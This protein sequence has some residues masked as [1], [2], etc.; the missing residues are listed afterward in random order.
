MARDTVGRFV[1]VDVHEDA[2]DHLLAGG[3]TRR[4]LLDASN[5]VVLQAKARAPHNTGAGAAG[6]HTEVVLDEGEW[7]ALTSWEQQE[8]YMYWHEKGSRYLPARP[9]LVPALRAAAS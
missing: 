4:M 2:I 5:P 8:F 9:F 7:A 6:I 1:S 3:D